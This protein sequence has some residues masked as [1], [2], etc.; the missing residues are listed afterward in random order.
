MSKNAPSNAGELIGEGDGED[1]VVQPFL[2][3]LEP[4]LEPI[5]LPMLWPDPDQ[6]N[7]GRLDEQGTQIAVASLCCRGLFGL[8][9][10]FVWVPARRRSRGLSRTHLQCRSRLP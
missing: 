8:R 6:H 10:R 1:V 4:R 2:G 5:A 9:S 7:P 3:R